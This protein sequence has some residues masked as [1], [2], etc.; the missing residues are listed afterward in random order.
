MTMHTC[1]MNGTLLSPNTV[2]LFPVH[3]RFVDSI[4]KT[5]L[6]AEIEFQKGESVQFEAHDFCCDGQHYRVNVIQSSGAAWTRNGT[7]CISGTF[8]QQQLIEFELKVE[9][10]DASGQASGNELIAQC[11]LLVQP[12]GRPV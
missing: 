1:K 11:R 12:Q 9:L 3:H 5:D 7:C 8:T 4:A 10:L 2:G 6:T